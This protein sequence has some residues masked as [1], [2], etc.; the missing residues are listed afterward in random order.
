MAI[1]WREALSVG[2]DGIDAD[3]KRLITLINK[4]DD[5]LSSD[6]PCSELREVVDQLWKY[7][8]E[9]FSREED[10]M[11]AVG[12]AKYDQHKRAHSDLI[13]QLR[14]ITQPILMGDPLP[15]TTGKLSKAI[16]DGLTGL[17]RHWLV[18]HI[19]KM[20]LQ[21]KPLLANRKRSY[22]P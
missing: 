9:H 6:R 20:D 15:A 4:T 22:S 14:L 3:H 11:I 5:L 21:L 19:L 2:N 16:R 8:Q 18:E 17:L 10:I 1:E 7:T 12:Y 13:E